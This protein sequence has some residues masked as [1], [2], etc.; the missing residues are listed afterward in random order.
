MKI[1]KIDLNY[2][3]S[4]WL[5]VFP[6]NELPDEYAQLV[7]SSFRNENC[8]EVGAMSALKRYEPMMVE[9]NEIQ[10]EIENV[11]GGLEDVE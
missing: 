2:I 4:L 9:F 8:G 7:V 11:T 6:I 1:D 3:K 5:N 10:L